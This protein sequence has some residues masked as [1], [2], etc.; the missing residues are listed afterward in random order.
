[1]AI[2]T[3]V[4]TIK[5]EADKL[6]VGETSSWQISE[7]QLEADTLTFET[8]VAAVNDYSISVSELFTEEDTQVWNKIRKEYTVTYGEKYFMITCSYPIAVVT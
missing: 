2:L 1:M 3:G 4:A 5:I 8:W 6:A 7:T